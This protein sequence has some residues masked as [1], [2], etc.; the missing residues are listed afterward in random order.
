[1]VR[2]LLARPPPL[3]LQPTLPGRGLGLTK[4]GLKP[5]KA[6]VRLHVNLLGAPL[7]PGKVH[8]E[9]VR[10]GGVHRARLPAER[11]LPPPAPAN[12]PLEELP[13]TGERASPLTPR[14]F[15]IPTNNRNISTIPKPTLRSETLPPT[16]LPIEPDSLVSPPQPQARPS[17]WRFHSACNKPQSR[18][19]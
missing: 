16:P 8:G 1:M 11:P 9:S 7:P 19:N 12:T 2:R 18:E 3:P 6:P 13:S 14:E 5:E 4:K 17:L 15:Q 10:A